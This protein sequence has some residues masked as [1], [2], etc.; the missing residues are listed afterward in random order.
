M[1]RNELAELDKNGSEI[2]RNM[3]SCVRT[4]FCN[5]PNLSEL[6]AKIPIFQKNKTLSKQF[7]FYCALK[8][9]YSYYWQAC[10]PEG[11]ARFHTAH[12]IIY[13]LYRLILIENEILFPSAR[14][15]E[16][17]VEKAKNKPENI[18]EKCK[19][20]MQTLS[21]EDCRIIIDSYEHWTTYNYPRDHN[22]I[23]NN[24]SDPFN[25]I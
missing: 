22:V 14:K 15:L 25:L 21:D 6:A 16:E 3:F 5:E 10:K 13:Y 24:F 4:L 8:M 7:N 1:T 19:K 12:G 9:L 20:F 17:Y 11:F 18:I 2:M 23:M